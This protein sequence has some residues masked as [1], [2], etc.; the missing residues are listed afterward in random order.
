MPMVPG[1]IG[2]G[3]A[4]PR[5]STRE[6]FV[7]LALA[8]QMSVELGLSLTECGVR[9]SFVEV[10]LAVTA[11]RTLHQVDC[12]E[13]EV[14][15]VGVGWILGQ[16]DSLKKVYVAKGLAPFAAPQTAETV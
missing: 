16:S 1:A 15:N 11:T 3:E 9:S 14:T 8:E 10:L 13:V 5:R 2:F 6:A 4:A 12:F 7:G